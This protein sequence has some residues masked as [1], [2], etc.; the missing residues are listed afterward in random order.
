MAPRPVG[1]VAAVASCFV[2]D[3]GVRG[4]YTY[5][6]DGRPVPI[7]ES[8]EVVGPLWISTRQAGETT[9]TV[10]ARL[11]AKMNG[12]GS[13]APGN[14]IRS[15]GPCMS[16][17]GMFRWTADKWRQPNR[18]TCMR[19]SPMARATIMF[20]IATAWVAF[21]GYSLA[22]GFWV[23]SIIDF[24]AGALLAYLGYRAINPSEPK[25]PVKPL[26]APRPPR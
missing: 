7:G 1:S 2:G 12:G 19:M 11:G 20:A 24:V 5:R 16:G 9:L 10:E 13:C 15:Q 23:L 22:A 17:L 4:F 14:G 18:L 3:A 6:F 21:G 26:R 8:F 25:G